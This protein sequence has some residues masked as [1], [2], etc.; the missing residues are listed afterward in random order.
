MA[1]SKPNQA[2]EDKP[3]EAVAP[4]N[5]EA[6]A[7]ADKPTPPAEKPATALIEGA[8][9]AEAVAS[10][11][12]P[13]QEPAAV[14]STETIAAPATAPEATT[15]T[16]EAQAHPGLLFAGALALLI[17]FI[18]YAVAEKDRAKR[19]I[20][21]VLA[22][23]VTAAAL[24][25]FQTFGMEKGIELQG[26]VSMEVKI[27]PKE[28]NEVTPA[29][30]DQVIDVLMKRLNALSTKEIILAKSGKDGI[31]LQ[32][33][34][35]EP[36]KLQEIKDKIA[37]VAELT[38]SVTH[39]NS[40]FMAQQV[41]LGQ[42]VVPGFEA[43]PYVL[44]DEEIEAG[45]TEPT[46]Y[47]LV[48]INRDMKGGSIKGARRTF[49]QGGDAIAVDF[50]SDGAKIMG[51]LTRE[52]VGRPL[53]II[54]D[55]EVISAPNINEP[56][57]S[58]CII[59]GDFT[60]EEAESLAASLENPLENPIYIAHSN[61]ISPTL[62]EATVKQ[63]LYAGIAGLA[64]TLFF[65]LIYY[66]FAGILALIGLGINIAIIFGAMALFGFTLTLPGIAGIILTIGVAIDANVLIYERLREEMAAGKSLG[67]AIN[68]AF[69]K[70][71]SAIID[72]N[73]T[74]LITAVLLYAFAEGTVKGFAI[75]L[76]IGILASMF[77]ALIVCRVAFKWALH[78]NVIKKLTFAN[79]VP[80]KQIDFL[81][82]RR[83]L[84]FVSII[85]FVASLIIVPLLD[86][87]GVELKGGDAI[88]IQSSEGLT[89]AGIEDALAD[90]ELAGTPIVQTQNPVG[91]DGEFFLVR[92]PDDS[93]ETIL[94]E[95]SKDLGVDVSDASISSVGSAVGKSMLTSSAIAL[96]IGILAIMFYVTLRFEFAFALGAIFALV[97]DLV[98]VA[99]I[100][101]LVGQEMTLIT[102]GAFLTIAGYSINDTI[103]VFDRVRETLQ[104]KRGN[105]K[106]IINIALNKT[107][108]RTLL[109]SITTLITVGVLWIFGGP[110]LRNFALTLVVGVVVGTY[111]SIFVAAPIVLWWAK[112][113]GTNLRREVLDTEQAKID[114]T[115]SPA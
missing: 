34:G 48:K 111:S 25:L 90:L 66:R 110:A 113:S 99:G 82:K 112:R 101:T 20:G 42:Q 65:I 27:Q 29:M 102:V 12:A 19:I 43:L 100:T 30:Q 37:Q 70:A 95:I 72:A 60:Q 87:R 16:P 56:F 92:A 39:P 75:T 62:G 86:P 10:E 78:W 1:D 107:L 67:A 13:A 97:H 57:S 58:N 54:V 68:T 84:S 73:I 33:P 40:R 11:T 28:G 32:M 44:T 24:L 7:P 69:E 93:A 46:R 64:I 79:I 53:A 2:T 103:V 104:M 31:F 77:A 85:A 41:A 88:E 94:S 109:T 89:Q 98:I 115:T 106:D 38:F 105:V 61:Y 49:G 17:G 52:N 51:T 71:F 108:A 15:S 81:G 14:E 114:A 3:A 76:I 91:A 50:T 45:I 21:A 55:E 80:G 96:G 6:V 4:S 22:V 83:A 18:A 8:E 26:G 23:V 63:G 5:S 36:E 9:A 59:T 35:V 47:E 74:T